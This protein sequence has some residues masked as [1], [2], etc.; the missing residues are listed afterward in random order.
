MKP[1][2]A[3]HNSRSKTQAQLLLGFCT[4]FSSSHEAS[5]FHQIDF[6]YWSERHSLKS[7]TMKKKCIMYI[8]KTLH[9]LTGSSINA[10]YN[11][12]QLLTQ[13]PVLSNTTASTPHPPIAQDSKAVSTLPTHQSSTHVTGPWESHLA[14][15]PPGII[16]EVT[17]CEKENVSPVFKSTRRIQGTTIQPGSPASLP[18][19]LMHAGR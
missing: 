16:T 7:V 4:L 9:V 14:V 5:T 10:G 11:T 15:T 18:T 3:V 13:T 8:P 2:P 19:G 1:S 17:V 6:C 12:H